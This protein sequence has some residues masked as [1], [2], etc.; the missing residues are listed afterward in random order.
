MTPVS[1]AATDRW[2]GMSATRRLSRLPRTPSPAPAWTSD[3]D[4]LIAR[5]TVR[6]L[7]AY[8]ALYQVDPRT[9]PKGAAQS[10][11]RVCESLCSTVVAMDELTT[12]VWSKAGLVP[13]D[14]RVDEWCGPQLVADQRPQVDDASPGRATRSRRRWSVH[15]PL[16]SHR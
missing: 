9:L 12:T 4:V 3:P 10:F 14:E 2:P 16:A 11:E 1:T 6:L 15:P 5:S 8:A 7:D 13:T